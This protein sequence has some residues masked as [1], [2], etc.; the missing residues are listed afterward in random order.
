M[1]Y[2]K[3]INFVIPKLAKWMFVLVINMGY[4]KMSDKSERKDYWGF[5]FSPLANS[6]CLF[7]NV[8]TSR[9]HPDM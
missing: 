7:L 3:V 2:V 9:S 1:K 5:F 6:V 8:A 4:N